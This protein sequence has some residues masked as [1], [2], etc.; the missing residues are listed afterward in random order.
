[1]SFF[2]S[3]LVLGK[4]F[5]FN[6]P[7]TFHI[8]LGVLSLDALLSFSVPPEVSA[9][10]SRFSPSLNLKRAPDQLCR[11]SRPVFSWPPLGLPATENFFLSMSLVGKS[12]PQLGSFELVSRQID[13]L[14][15]ESF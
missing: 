13:A 14:I 12:S 15:S 8:L 2:I 10:C 7:L 3:E 5:V 11:F 9:P 1:M 4:F 6:F